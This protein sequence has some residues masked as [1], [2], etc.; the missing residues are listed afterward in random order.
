MIPLFVGITLV[1]LIALA[2]TC[3]LGYGVRAGH[4]LSPYHE[5]VGVLAT[6]ACFAA[7]CIVFTYFMATA[8]WLQHAISVKQLDPALAEPTRS[9][10]QQAFPA[11]LLAMSVTFL[12]AVTGAITFSYR[13]SPVWHHAFAIV[14]L[15]ANIAVALIEYRA[16]SRNGRLIDDVLARIG[17]SQTNATI[18]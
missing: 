17:T 7:H 2:A 15:I 5:L 1:N 8:K 9:F 18:V 14:A 13:I 11:A 6:L 3:A 12:A 4:D 10:K 16:I